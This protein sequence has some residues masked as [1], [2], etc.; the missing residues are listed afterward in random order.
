[1]EISLSEAEIN[2]T[3]ASIHLEGY[4]AGISDASKRNINYNITKWYGNQI[5]LS[6][7]V[8]LSYWIKSSNKNTSD[9]DLINKLLDST[10]SFFLQ[11]PNWEHEDIEREPIEYYLDE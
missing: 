9:K 2:Y 8:P 4:L 10:E 6:L 1:M 11:N 7:D 3:I 5:K